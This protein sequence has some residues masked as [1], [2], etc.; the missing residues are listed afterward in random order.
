M[1]LLLTAMRHAARS[2]EIAELCIAFRDDEVAG[3]DIAGA[4]AGFPAHQASGRL[5]VPAP[6]ERAFHHPCRRGV[7]VAVDLGGPAVVRCGSA[8]ARGADR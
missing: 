6:G 4:E 1:R 5:R 7:R 8:R 3:F 2:R